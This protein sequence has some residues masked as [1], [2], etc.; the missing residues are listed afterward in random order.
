M[1]KKQLTNDPYAAA[2]QQLRDAVAA[3]ADQ[4]E[5]E[6]QL[7]AAAARLA[8]HDHLYTKKLTLT[9]DDGHPKTFDAYRFQHNAARGPYKGGLR[10]HPQVSESEVKALSMWMTWKCAITNLPYGGAKGGIAVDPHELSPR[11]L[12]ALSRAWTRAFAP[13]I[14]P[15]QD[16]PAP[17]VNTN[18][19][20]M[21]WMADELIRLHADDL[22]QNYAATF[23]GKPL[24]FGG[25]QGREEATGLGG[26]TVLAALAR[27]QK[28][29][30]ADTAIA[31][32]GFGN[33]GA[34][35]ARHA[36]R[37]GFKVVAVSDSRH[38]LYNSHGLDI[39]EAA[40]AK[41]QYRRFNEAH[42]A[43][44]VNGEIL[45]AADILSLD[46][47]V[48]VPAALE[49]AITTDNAHTIK[50][51]LIFEMANGPTTPDA[52]K[53]L[54]SQGKMVM[55]DIL[56]N[57]GGVTTS[58]FEW[59]QNLSGDTWSYDTVLGKLTPLMERSFADVW[60]MHQRRPADSLR[61]AAYLIAVKKVID[62]MIIRGQV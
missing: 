17:D 53:Y 10:F 58:Y 44:K 6:S 56:D 34:W 14:G 15:W 52:E 2:C 28:M 1:S 47:N 50:A 38:T 59:V 5:D 40:A 24:I 19:Q 62:A 45:P 51:P 23:T 60:A 22:T 27:A 12:Q 18:G 57:A 37:L 26:A 36:A 33:V 9:M 20:I 8:T 25:S 39:D 49:N 30:I 11:E 7:Q 55:P 16:V 31:V 21:A 43:G 41:R 48:L 29:K 32:Q 61:Q 13:Y 46:V 35:F 3:L 42:S 54:V 4:Y